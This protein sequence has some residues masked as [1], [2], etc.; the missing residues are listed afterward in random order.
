MT[1]TTTPHSL[2][3]RLRRALA[4]DRTDVVLRLSLIVLVTNSVT[5]PLLFVAAAVLAVVALPRP[6]LYRSPLLW[7]AFGAALAARVLWDWE[8]VDNHVILTVWWAFA[9]GVSLL[10]ADAGRSLAANA[11]LLV[12]LAFLFATLWKLISGEFVDGSFFHYSLLLDDRFRYLA[13]SMGGLGHDA[14]V[15]NHGVVGGLRDSSG[16]GPAGLVTTDAIRMTAAVL[17][18]WTLAI[19]AIV[20]GA[21]LVPVRR[22]AWVRHG[23]LLV[24]AFTTYLAVPVGGFGVLLMV[25]GL[26]QCDLGDRARLHWVA[27][28][29]FL[30]VW[31]PLW[32]VL[33]Y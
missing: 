5:Y 13:E 26:A 7:F 31:A 6:R 2:T 28:F 23:S 12:G 17:T 1:A 9:V 18:W 8:G 19:E 14:Y 22:L 32:R 11:R 3:A 27:A 30:L 4:G 10:G 29:A 24:F 16:S 20:A 25:M 21:F 33:F 15:S